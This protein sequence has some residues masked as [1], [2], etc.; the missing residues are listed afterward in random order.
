MGLCCVVMLRRHA[1]SSR[2]EKHGP[3]STLT[4]LDAEEY[5]PLLLYGK[6]NFIDLLIESCNLGYSQLC[7]HLVDQS[8]RALPRHSSLGSEIQSGPLIRGHQYSKKTFS[9]PPRAPHHR[10]IQDLPL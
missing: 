2:P 3:F 5:L 8:S 1:N 6:F 4:L 7:L 10:S 9:C